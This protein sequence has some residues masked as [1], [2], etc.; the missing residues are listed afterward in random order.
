MLHIHLHLDTTT[1]IRT[2]GRNL[3][4]FKQSNALLDIVKVTY[5][6]FHSV[7]LEGVNMW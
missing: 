3:G 7:N 4:K 1:I 6:Y 5:K 2:S